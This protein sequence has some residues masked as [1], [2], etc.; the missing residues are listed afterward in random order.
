MEALLDEPR[1][2]WNY[3]IS[4]TLSEVF[5]VEAIYANDDCRLFWEGVGPAVQSDGIS[6]CCVNSDL[7]S[8]LDKDNN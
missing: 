8:H 1:K 7:V 5:R 6:H 2:V 3:A 4:C